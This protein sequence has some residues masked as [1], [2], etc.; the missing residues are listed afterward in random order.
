MIRFC[1][2]KHAQPGWS[3]RRLARYRR[4][5]GRRQVLHATRGW[6]VA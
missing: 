3:A 2:F 5:K 6:K 4:L 1:R